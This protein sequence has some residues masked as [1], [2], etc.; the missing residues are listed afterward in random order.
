M[1][2]T[3]RPRN[4]AKNHPKKEKARMYEEDNSSTMISVKFRQVSFFVRTS[5][6]RWLSG[7]VAS[8]G[9]AGRDS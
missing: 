2:D 8:V 7:P 4:P 1:V 9:V 6:D 5:V 3:F